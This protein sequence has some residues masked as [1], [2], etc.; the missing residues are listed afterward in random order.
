MC[1]PSLI[2]ICCKVSLPDKDIQTGRLIT[3]TFDYLPVEENSSV[4]TP[5][6]KYE[7][8]RV[9]HEAQSLL[10]TKS[11]IRRPLVTVRL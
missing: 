6:L 8:R 10:I 9:Q 3:D 11:S 4:D 5:V 7:L 2:H 1:D